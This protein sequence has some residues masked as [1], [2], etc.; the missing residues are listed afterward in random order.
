MRLVGEDPTRVELSTDPLTRRFVGVAI[1]G[2]TPFDVPFISEIVPG[3]YQGGCQQDLILPDNI[4]HV[5]SLYPWERY[6]GTEGLDLFEEF[7]L[8]D[9]ADQP[10]MPSIV[11]IAK[12]VNGARKYGDTL[13]HCQAGLNRSGLVAGVALVL[14][15][16]GPQE[17]LDTLRES[18][19]PVVLCNKT[20]EKALL[21][22]KPEDWE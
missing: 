1:H 5:I 22:F 14:E 18:R 16:M 21:D 3:F 13:V 10:D 12:L 17:A 9:S 11:A 4:K 7:K 20:F 8:Y 2:N 15:G 19:S 6:Y